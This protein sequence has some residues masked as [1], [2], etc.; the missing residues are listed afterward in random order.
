MDSSGRLFVGDRGNNRI[1][2]FDQDG[3]FLAE[4]R[5]FGRPTAIYIDA[6]DTVYVADHASDAK[7]NPGFRRGIRIGSVK[8]GVVRT[9]IP[10][11]GPDPD[12]Q[13][14][15][16]KTPGTPEKNDALTDQNMQ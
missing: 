4:W 10:A 5:Q 11:V 15:S 6:S 3:K 1:Q 12:T 13:N 14:L 7:R 16:A 9:M 8:D 2:I